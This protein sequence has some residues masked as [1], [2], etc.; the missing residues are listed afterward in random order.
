MLSVLLSEIRHDV[1]VELFIRRP[2]QQ[3]SVAFFGPLSQTLD[4]QFLKSVDIRSLKERLESPAWSYRF[5]HGHAVKFHL[6]FL[7]PAV[8]TNQDGLY[9]RQ[10]NENIWRDRDSAG[11]EVPSICPSI[12]D[13]ENKVR[14]HEHETRCYEDDP[15]EPRLRLYFFRLGTKFKTKNAGQH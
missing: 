9:R 12:K 5:H 14:M 15:V 8:F 6:V 10:L 11:A 3:W 2:A 4:L 13:D 7:F 1:W